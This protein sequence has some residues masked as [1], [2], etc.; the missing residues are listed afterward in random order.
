MDLLVTHPEIGVVSLFLLAV[1]LHVAV[2]AALHHFRLKDF[3][4][5][6]FGAF[7]E[8]DLA[9]T[10]AIVI[11]VSFASTLFTTA[12]TGGDLKLAFGPAFVVLV[13]SCAS[14][15]LPI[16]RDTLYEVQQLVTGTP[17]P[18]LRHA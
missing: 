10:R 14:A 15:T 9:S 3:D 13:A 11:G 12:F 4:W 8:T 17:V 16:L 18:Q 6:K 1:G 5:N 2:G 7:V